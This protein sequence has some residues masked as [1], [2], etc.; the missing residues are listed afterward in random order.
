MLKIGN[1]N[2]VPIQNNNH[3]KMVLVLLCVIFVI[4]ITARLSDSTK[5]FRD[6]VIIQTLIRLLKQVEFRR[7]YR[8]SC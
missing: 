7:G 4:K 1:L 2:N 8:I 6:I 3:G 5:S